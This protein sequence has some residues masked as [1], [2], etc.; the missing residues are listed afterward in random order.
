MTGSLIVSGICLA[1]MQL[2]DML[3]PQQFAPA[4][5][6]CLAALPAVFVWYIALRLTRHELLAEVHSLA[7]SA[8]GKFSRLHPGRKT[9]LEG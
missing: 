1:V 2:S 5:R 3:I 9:D 6:L 8:K 4:L 7:V